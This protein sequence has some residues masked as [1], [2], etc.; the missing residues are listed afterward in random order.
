MAGGVA[1]GTGASAAFWASA[2][3]RKDAQASARAARLAAERCRNF[4]QKIGFCGEDGAL[5]IREKGGYF[6]GAGAAGVAGGGPT[7]TQRSL[8]KSDSEFPL[9]SSPRTG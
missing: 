1:S 2:G 8:A 9:R 7:V 4:G 3:W 6:F 5:C